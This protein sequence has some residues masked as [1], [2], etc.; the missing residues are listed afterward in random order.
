MPKIRTMKLSTPDVATH[1]LKKR[2]YIYY[3]DWK[4]FEK[5]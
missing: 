1:L 2:R 3:K 4:N 5:N